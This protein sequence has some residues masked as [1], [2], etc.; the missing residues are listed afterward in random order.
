[1]KYDDFDTWVQSD[2][3]ASDYEAWQNL[4]NWEENEEER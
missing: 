4:S 1:M 2:E 3:K